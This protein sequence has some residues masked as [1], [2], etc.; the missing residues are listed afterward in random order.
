[1]VCANVCYAHPV[2]VL[3]VDPGELGELLTTLLGQYGFSAERVISGE[4]ALTRGLDARPAV[5][6]IEAELPDASG[7]EVAEL[8]RDELSAKV[9]L[10]YPPAFGADDATVPGRIRALSG[11]FAR[12]FR[13]L[14]LIEMVASQ[15]GRRLRREGSADDINDAL[16]STEGYAID[17]LSE[18]LADDLGEIDVIL[19]DIVDDGAADDQFVLE[20]FDPTANVPVPASVSDDDTDGVW[21]TRTSSISRDGATLSRDAARPLDEVLVEQERR[22]TQTFNVGEL[23]ELWGRVKERRTSTK[24]STKPASS[25]ALTPRHLA[26]LLDA[27][28]QSQ[29]TGE[30]W[31]GDARGP[32]RRVLLLQRGVI[33]GARSNI[34][35]EDL[36]TLLRRRKAITDEDADEIN[37][38]LAQKLYRTATEAVVAQEHVPERAL[39]SVLEEHVR[40]VAIAAFTWERGRYQL[41]L[42]GRAT[43]EAL[44]VDVHVGDVIVHAI[45][46]T[47]SDEA[48]ALAAPDDARFAPV[49]DA[50][51][52]LE[53]LKLSPAEARVVISMDGTKTISDLIALQSPM[54][55]RTIRGLAAGLFCL[56]LTRFQGRGPAKARNISFF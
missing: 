7:L 20:D 11:A 32:G 39:R 34:Q 37:F 53:H 38:M 5:V 45:T 6:V 30:L 29:T 52:G 10:T 55:E 17:E 33:V 51:Y 22:H 14:S 4:D 46:L 44:Q 43:K 50:V 41:T 56:Q 21:R 25:G 16:S 48:L 28:H 13:S 47:E 26:D 8:F 15:L 2:D 24:P 9:I 40:R 27:F 49:G 3:V 18:Q 12:P 23:A 54:P 36:L 35:G 19:T 42:D 31:L 1:M